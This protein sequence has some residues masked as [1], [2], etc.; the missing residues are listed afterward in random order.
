M[1]LYD[2][3][4]A[5]HLATTSHALAVLKIDMQ[6]TVIFKPASAVRFAH[7]LTFSAIHNL[8]Y[9]DVPEADTMPQTTYAPTAL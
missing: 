4:Y 2:P 8:S 1:A 3:G 5:E 9:H 7:D 6:C